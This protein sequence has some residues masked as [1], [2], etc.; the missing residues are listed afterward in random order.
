[1]NESNFLKEIN[2]KK[3]EILHLFLSTFCL[4]NDVKTEEE[5]AQLFDEYGL[6]FVQDPSNPINCMYYLAKKDEKANE[7]ESIDE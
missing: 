6:V 2:E 1:M 5:L 3:S 4:L 7:Y